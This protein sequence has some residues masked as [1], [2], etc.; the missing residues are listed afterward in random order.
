MNQVLISR[1][2][3]VL[4]D[5]CLLALKEEHRVDSKGRA[6]SDEVIHELC[7]NCFDFNKP[8]IDDILG[9]AE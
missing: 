8:L 4:C 3:L 1:G 7:V 9:S 6:Q 2:F 5:L